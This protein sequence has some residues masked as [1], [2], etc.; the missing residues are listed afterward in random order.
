MKGSLSLITL[1][2]IMVSFR[3]ALRRGNATAYVASE[4]RLDVVL[5]KT[6]EMSHS[7]NDASDNKGE[8]LT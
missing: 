6:I 2:D 5:V 1:V 3:G 7:A 8:W 4:G